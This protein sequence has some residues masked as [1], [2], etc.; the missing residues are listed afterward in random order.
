VVL[1]SIDPGNL[2]LNSHLDILKE[3]TLLQ[4]VSIAHI[5]TVGGSGT[6]RSVAERIVVQ[7]ILPTQG[8]HK[9]I[10]GPQKIM[11]F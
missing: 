10:L 8:I 1:G 2:V 7:S 11:G 9:L 3:L 6:N 5:S 4:G